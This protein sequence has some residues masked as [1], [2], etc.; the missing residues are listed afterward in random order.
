MIIYFRGKDI[1]AISSVWLERYVDIVEVTGSSPVSPIGEVIPVESTGISPILFFS[2]KKIKVASI[3]PTLEEIFKTE[4]IFPAND[5]SLPRQRRGASRGKNSGF[6]FLRDNT[7]LK[8]KHFNAQ[9]R[10]RGD[11]FNFRH[12]SAL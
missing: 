9:R 7:Y 4:F 2:M 12:L 6:R 8:I 5:W 3:E 11:T 10:W 1:W